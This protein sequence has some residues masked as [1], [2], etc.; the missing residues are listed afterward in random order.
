MPEAAVTETKAYYEDYP[1]IEGGAERI[2]WWQDYLREF[3]PEDEHLKGRLVG[4]IG[5][6]IGEIS[7][8]I[9][10]RG[11]RPVCL[12]LTLR[13]LKRNGE[14]NPEAV[15]FNGSA[16]NLPFADGAF[17]HTISI[18]VLMVTPDCKKGISEV[19]R[20]TAP[21]GTVVL[22][23]YNTWSY[24]NLMYKLWAPI[25]KLIPLEKAPGWMVK[26]MQPF[27]RNHLGTEVSEPV[28][29]RLLGD[30]LWTPHATFHTR[31]ELERWGR[32]FGLE[33]V[34]HKLFYHH[35]AHMLT[36][37][38]QGTM[39]EEPR[40]EVLFRCPKC[41]EQPIKPTNGAYR[42]DPCA[43]TFEPVDGIYRCLV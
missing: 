12:D 6:S 31:G 36:F 40:Q 43:E 4:D 32:E 30:K 37:R 26:G 24:L 41:G 1:F 18:G 34:H 3:L 2:A 27:V 42:C 28:L 5:S 10:N 35:Y 7:R 13:A 20:V 23:I 8:G 25:R 9:A 11:A 29:R 14:I 33:P 21:G 39:S 15:R 17:D 16:L 22:F 19:A 38:K